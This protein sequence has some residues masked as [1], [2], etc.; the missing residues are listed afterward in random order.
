MR[1]SSKI[2]NE[3]KTKGKSR[4]KFDSKKVNSGNFLYKFLL[5]HY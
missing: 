3:K 4:S 5:K 2:V 1:A